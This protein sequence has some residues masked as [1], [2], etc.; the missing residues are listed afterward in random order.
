MD[1]MSMISVLMT[2]IVTLVTRPLSLFKLACLFGVKTVVII[3]CTWIELVRAAICF[4]VNLFWR[5]TMLTVALISLPVRILNALQSEK[6][7]SIIFA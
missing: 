4:H 6:Q 2:T 3:I 1:P 7:V 5:I